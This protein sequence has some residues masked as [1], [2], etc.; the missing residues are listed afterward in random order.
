M[1]FMAFNLLPAH[2]GHRS[3]VARR[4]LRMPAVIFVVVFSN[5]F[6]DGDGDASTLPANEIGCRAAA[7]AREQPVQASAW[8]PT[9]EP[10]AAD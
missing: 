5:E 6:V 9:G 4:T 1:P 8:Q 7:V 2:S 3:H 10:R